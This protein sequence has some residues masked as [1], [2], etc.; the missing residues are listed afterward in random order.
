MYRFQIAAMAWIACCL[1]NPVWSEDAPQGDQGRGPFFER[2]M[3]EFDKDG[4]GKLNEEERAT[5]L[6]LTEQFLGRLRE[7][8]NAGP[9][10]EFGNALKQ[11][12]KDGDGKLND[13][14]RAAAMTAREGFGKKGPPAGADLD[15]PPEFVLKRFDKDGDGKLNDEEKAAVIKNREE[16]RKAGI[17]PGRP[18]LNNP[19]EAVLKRFDKD[20]DGKWNESERAA[21]MEAM[22]KMGGRPGFPSREEMIK[23]FDKDGDGKLNATEEAAGRAEM[24]KR[25]GGRSG[26]AGGLAPGEGKPLESKLDKAELIEKFDKNGDGKLN[27]DER[28]EALKGF[29][30]RDRQK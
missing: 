23:R 15:N 18:N 22:A 12:D 7:R 5:A 30:K 20:G 16:M 8:G 11:F 28:A 13:D 29:Q 3:K 14:E 17:P 6:R 19:P 25:F 21:A 9:R 26:A 10:P 24:E 2:M 27:D 1:T 4:D